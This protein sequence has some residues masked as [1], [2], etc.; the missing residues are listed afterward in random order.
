MQAAPF[1]TPQGLGQLLDRVFRLYRLRF[2][3]L[4]LT[5]ALFFVP[6]A[7][8]AAL[9]MGVA[10]NSYLGLL[11]NA[12]DLPAPDDG[13]LL[14]ASGATLGLSL[15]VTSAALVVGALAFLALLVQADANA[16]DQ[17]LAIVVTIRVA[18][19]R[20]WAF[21]GLSLLVSLI[22][23][24][25]LIF[26][27]FGAIIL[28]FVFAG[29]I[30]GLAAL[31]EGNGMVAVGAVLL[32][33]GLI[34]VMVF[35]MLLP[36]AY[37]TTRWLVA[38]VVVLTEHC[39][40]VSALSR[41]WQLTNGSFWRLFGLLVLLFLLNSVVVGLPVSLLQFFAVLLMSSQWLGIANGVLTGMGY[42]VSILW[43]P[44]LALT[45]VLAYYDLRVRTENLDLAVRIQALE[46]AVRPP[47]LPTP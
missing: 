43:Y 7:V 24:G 36:V 40:P 28:A 30:A 11:L 25:A 20:F 18:L 9:L 42:L 17:E 27:Y 8:V 22:L 37:L 44:F 3:K 29:I 6:L 35:L 34:F 23:I 15:F 47:T 2:G 38:P 19:T 32:I 41:S 10:M 31:S 21:I 39:G 5:A 45:L 33:I 14:R 13:A 1:T 12:F 4:V 16:N 46:R 26:V